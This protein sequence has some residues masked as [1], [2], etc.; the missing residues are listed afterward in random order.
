MK[1]LSEDRHLEPKTIIIGLVLVFISIC[2]L[3][4]SLYI[5]SKEKHSEE[6]LIEKTLEASK[7]SSEQMP[8][9]NEKLGAFQVVHIETAME[10]ARTT[11]FRESTIDRDIYVDVSTGEVTFEQL[12]SLYGINE[13]SPMR[14]FML[15]KLIQVNL[16]SWTSTPAAYSDTELL[17][18]VDF[19]DKVRAS[20]STA[21]VPAMASFGIRRRVTDPDVRSIHDVTFPDDS[22]ESR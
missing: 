8:S 16:D 11:H 17:N 21:R 1:K 22:L 4:T 12:V 3:L 5:K 18:E 15:R 6:V 9:L 14:D 19:T 10:L 2:L 20:A 13:G 7:T